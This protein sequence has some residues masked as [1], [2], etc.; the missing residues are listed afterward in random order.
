MRQDYQQFVD[1]EAEVVVVGPEDQAAFVR[2]WEKERY[3]FVGIPDPVQ[4]VSDLFGQEV[5]LLQFGRMPALMVID[6]AGQIVYT[7]YGA[8]MQDIPK[9]EEILDVIQ[10]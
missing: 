7:H 10:K 9:N 1:R 8:S 2:E 6:P 3:P 4:A 5:K